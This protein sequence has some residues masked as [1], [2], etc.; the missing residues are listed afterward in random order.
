MDQDTNKLAGISNRLLTMG[1]RP[2]ASFEFGFKI[3]APQYQ[4][5]QV[6]VDGRRYVF[7]RGSFQNAGTRIFADKQEIS[8]GGKIPSADQWCSLAATLRDDTLKFYYNEQFEWECKV[9]EGTGGKH[10]IHAGFASHG[11]TIRVKDFYLET[12]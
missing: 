8:H 6:Y 5:I 1:S 3:K 10:V 9:P 2:V 12:K 11:G 7:A 4:T